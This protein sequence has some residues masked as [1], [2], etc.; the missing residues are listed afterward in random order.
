MLRERETFSKRGGKYL[1][2]FGDISRE[3]QHTD[4]YTHTYGFFGAVWEPPR[5][6][7]EG[8]P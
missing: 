1:C 5:L 2:Y 8:Q 3:Y 7:I 6:D 4:K